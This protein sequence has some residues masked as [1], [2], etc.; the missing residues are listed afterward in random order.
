MIDERL[1]SVFMDMVHGMTCLVTVGD[2]MFPDLT[3][4]KW[5]VLSIER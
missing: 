5:S 4:E 1:L 3:T 2:Q